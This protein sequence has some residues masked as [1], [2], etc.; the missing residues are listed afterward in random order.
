MW[1]ATPCIKNCLCPR[2][3]PNLKFG[4]RI[5]ETKGIPGLNLGRPRQEAVIAAAGGP[6]EGKAGPPHE[7]GMGVVPHP[8][9][10]TAEAMGEC[11]MSRPRWP[12]QGANETRSPTEAA[13]PR[14]TGDRMAARHA[15]TKV[16]TGSG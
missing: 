9:T 6:E 15:L 4:T 3:R 16:R 10:S 14:G 8:R 7:Y 5:G 2:V 12:W 1:G 11:R 13:Y